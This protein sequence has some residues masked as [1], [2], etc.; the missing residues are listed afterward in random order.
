MSWKTSNRRSIS[1]ST[2]A[3]A[4]LRSIPSKAVGAAR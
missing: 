1:A 2:L 4:A 3:R